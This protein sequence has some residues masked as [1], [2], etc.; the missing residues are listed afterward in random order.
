M[1]E[2]SRWHLRA[3]SFWTQLG[4]PLGWKLPEITFLGIPLFFS[5]RLRIVSFWRQL[6]SSLELARWYLVINSV[7]RQIGSLLVFSI[8]G[9]PFSR[10][11]PCCS[12]LVLLCWF[13][14]AELH[15][16]SLG[17]NNASP[18]LGTYV[19]HQRTRLPAFP[20]IHIQTTYKIDLNIKLPVSW[21]RYLT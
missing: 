15:F 21:K 5:W 20:S 13:I 7:W 12:C 11:P 9:Y 18:F 3:T 16:P 17:L 6:G 4:S 2:L 1:K 10:I 19:N 8:L 14:H